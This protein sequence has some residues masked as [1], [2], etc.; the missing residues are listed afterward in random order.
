M[1][2]LHGALVFDLKI[3][4]NDMKDF[5][6]CRPKDQ[7]TIISFQMTRSGSWRHERV[8]KGSAMQQK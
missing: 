5:I 6:R 7:F 8:S 4:M 1:K 3:R 2:R